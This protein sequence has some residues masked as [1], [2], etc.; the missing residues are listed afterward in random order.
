MRDPERRERI[1]AA[2]VQLFIDRG[3]HAVNI[4]DIGGAAGIV[5]TGIYRHYKNKA[6]ILVEVCERVVDRLVDDAE[7]TMRDVDD[8]LEVL[9]ALVRRQAEF[10]IDDRKL[11]LAYVLEARNLPES[12]E[13][14]LRWKQRH[15]V[16]LWID[17]LRAVRPDI[18]R[19]EANFLVGAGISAIHSLLRWGT[20]G[21]PQERL[22]PM[23]EQAC[24]RA[25]DI[26]DQLAARSVNGV[27]GSAQAS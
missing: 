18:D 10:T 13:R 5:G 25:M 2:A 22:A 20:S 4:G 23:L 16:E 1:L 3:Y 7:A 6:A 24:Y 11:Y 15:Y 19:A 9:V 26:A 12:D 8:P 17:M 21:M 14:R 27:D